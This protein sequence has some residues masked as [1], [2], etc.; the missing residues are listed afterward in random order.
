MTEDGIENDRVR[1][2]FHLCWDASYRVDLRADIR[3]GETLEASKREILR[4]KSHRI[5]IYFYYY[6]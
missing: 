2:S 4:K 1:I 3:R 6:C 5:D